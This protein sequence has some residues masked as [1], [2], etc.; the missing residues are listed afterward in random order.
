MKLAGFS[1]AATTYSHLNYQLMDG[2]NYLQDNAL[3]CKFSNVN[4]LVN[5]KPQRFPEVALDTSDF[6]LNP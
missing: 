3:P 4:L 6:V 2:P 1:G 5:G